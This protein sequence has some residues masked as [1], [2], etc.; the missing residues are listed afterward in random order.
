MLSIS[1]QEFDAII[2]QAMDELPQEYITRLNNVAVVYED[3][4]TP[5]QREKL[6]LRCDQSLFGLYEGIP[7]TKRGAGYNFVLPDKITIFKKPILAFS[8]DLAAFKKQVKH[9][10]W[11]EI[12]HFYGLDHDRIHSLESK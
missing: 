5:E 8:S 7:L 6:K 10:L 3:E 4:P 9:T 2:T 11:H 1:D 12:A